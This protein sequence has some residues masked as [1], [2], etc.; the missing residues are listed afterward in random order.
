MAGKFSQQLLSCASVQ[1]ACEFAH[2]SGKVPTKPEFTICMKMPRQLLNENPDRSDPSRKHRMHTFTVLRLLWWGNRSAGRVPLRRVS[3]SALQW[4]G[5]GHQWNA[6]MPGSR[7][8]RASRQ[9]SHKDTSFGKPVA[10]AGGIVPLM[11]SPRRDSD[12]SA[13][14][15]SAHSV[16]RL[17]VDP[18][19]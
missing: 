9:V 14:N 11:L 15:P 12:V 3:S 7:P 4:A 6:C 1:L 17:L 10:H 19:C 8:W 13:G 2:F 5:G 16:G 18:G